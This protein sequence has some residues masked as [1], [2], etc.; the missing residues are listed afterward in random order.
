[1]KLSIVVVGRGTM[2]VDDLAGVFGFE[3]MVD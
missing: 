2:S 1:M 3:Q